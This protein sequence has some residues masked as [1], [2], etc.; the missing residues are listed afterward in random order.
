MRPFLLGLAIVLLLLVPGCANAPPVI[1]YRTAYIPKQLLRCLPPVHRNK[2]V[3]RISTREGAALLAYYKT[4]HADC[5][6]K[7]VA[8]ARVYRKQT[9][10]K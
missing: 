6:R 7:V 5:Y 4:A 3:V 8:F 9:G 2:P 1:E 10:G